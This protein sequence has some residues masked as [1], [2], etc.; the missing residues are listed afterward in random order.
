MSESGITTQKLNKPHI[1]IVRATPNDAETICDIRDRAWLEAY[2]NV[3]LGIT[4]DDIKLN[5]QGQDGEFIP[6]RIAYLKDQ[7]AKDDGPGLATLVAKVGSKVV[8]YINP[9]ID[10]QGRRHIGAIYVAPETQGKGVGGKLMQKILSLLGRDED[11]FLEVISYNQNAI[12]FYERFGF[13]QTETT[14]RDEEGRPDYM[15]SLPQV[16]MVLKAERTH[17]R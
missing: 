3:E 5:A 1:E 13:K 16:E 8:G 12:K 14:I 4:V 10:E 15:K 6:R 17:A 9:R 7:L 2:P 11:I